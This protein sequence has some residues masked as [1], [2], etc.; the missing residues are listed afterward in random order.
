MNSNRGRLL[1]VKPVTH[2]NSAQVNFANRKKNGDS[3]AKTPARAW[4]SRVGP[5]S[6][7]R[8]IVWAALAHAR[9]SLWWTEPRCELGR[10]VN[11]FS[12]FLA[13]YKCLF[14]IVSS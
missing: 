11:S 6:R 5:L 4:V 9:G 1:D 14:N 3:F 13:I 8:A 10:V 7:E 12:H 2:S